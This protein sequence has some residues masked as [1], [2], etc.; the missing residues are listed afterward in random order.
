MFDGVMNGKAVG[1]PDFKLDLNRNG[2]LEECYFDF[3]YSPIRM[4]NGK[5]G[6]VLVTVIET[7]NKKKAEEALKDSEKRF[8]TMADNIPQLA[9]M[10]DNKGW[11]YWYNKRWFDYTGTNLKEMQGWQWK[12]VH[13][14]E[15]IKNVEDKFRKA[16]K[17]ADPWEDTFPLRRADGAFRWFLSRAYPIRNEEG[18]VLQWFG[19]NT[20]ITEQI[21]AKQA[22]TESEQRF[23]TMAEATDLLIAVGDETGNGIF[24]NKAWTDFTGKPLEELLKLDWIDLIH[25]DDRDNYLNVFVNAFG[26]KEAFIG[27]FRVMNKEG[28]YRWLLVQ[29]PPRFNTDGTFAGYI[30]SGI[31]ITERKHAEKILQQ[32]EQ[33]LR[34]T[35]IQAPVAMAILKGKDFV[36][37]LANARMYELWGKPAEILM[38]RPIFE[39]LTEAKDQGFEALLEGV[40]KT[41]VNYSANGMPIYLP[42]NG[43]QELVYLNYVYE[44]YR[45]ADGKVT[46]ILVVAIDV[47]DQV[48][49]R[50]KIEEVV[51]ERTKEL[52]L[53]NNTLQKTNAELAQFA[54][55]A[56]HDLQEPL[57]KITTFSQMLE[58][59]LGDNLNEPS[60]KF[61]QKI[62]TSSSRMSALIRDV[63]NY[64][65]LGKENVRFEKVDLNQIVEG[66]KADYDLLIEQKQAIIKTNHLPVLEAIPLQMAQLL[67][68]LIGNSLKFSRAGHPPVIEIVAEKTNNLEVEPFVKSRNWRIIKFK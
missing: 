34:N 2:F 38:N 49:A 10:A 56:S 33:N 23:R 37:E 68:N 61:L 45:E 66:V 42:R 64:S 22:L 18:A 53:T 59:S 16:I 36:V 48:K 58:D 43:K 5:V 27:E 6:G 19:T 28:K 65:Q 12:K 11:I 1:F 44:P 13:H 63:L 47:T 67:G 32:S 57:R 17:M 4:D 25:P 60:K 3:S 50:H 52:E 8:R 55:I 35:I 20:D 54:Y 51:A 15:Y 24:F 9:W 39:G 41:G 31:D 26:K 7:T 30:S 40:L 14:P 62:N 46:G 29:A 21:E